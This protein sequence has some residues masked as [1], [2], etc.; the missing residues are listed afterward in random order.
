M[1]GHNHEQLSDAALAREIEAAFGVDPSPEFL[2]R[3]RARIATERPGQGWMWSWRWVEA[4]AVLAGVAM[5][6]V[7]TLREPVPAPHDPRLTNASPVASVNQPPAL[8]ESSGQVPNPV[9]VSG[10]RSARSRQPAGE[11]QPQV[12]V[13]PGEAVALRQLMVAIAARQ[14]E[15]IDI[16]KLGG[17]SAPLAPI[18][19]I[20]LEP[21]ELSPIAGLEGE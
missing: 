9:S 8:V 1:D 18:E 17:E 7:W 3:I 16:P 15:A 19:Q 11:V 2:P 14:V 20:V 10:I 21:I 5:I 12:V 13:S 4:V 6:A